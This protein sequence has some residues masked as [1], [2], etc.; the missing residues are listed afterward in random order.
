MLLSKQESNIDLFFS[1][2]RHNNIDFY[3]ISQSYSHLS[4]NIIG[5]NSI[6]VN[7]L[8]QT[9]RDIILLFHDIS[10]LDMNLEEWKKLCCKAWEI[11]HDYLQMDRFAKIG[12]VRYT[13]RNCNKKTF[14]VCTPE[15]KRF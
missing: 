6:K 15:T 2:G 3:Y 11:D 13:I 9:L 7:F 12:D 14:I 4:K 1:R 10:G 5:N 8:K